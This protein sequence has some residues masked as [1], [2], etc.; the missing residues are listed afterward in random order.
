MEGIAIQRVSGKNTT[1]IVFLRLKDCTLYLK[2]SRQYLLSRARS[3]Y[4]NNKKGVGT[5]LYNKQGNKYK[6]VAYHFTGHPYNA[7]FDFN[8]L[9]YIHFGNQMKL[10]NQDNNIIHDFWN[11]DDCNHFLEQKGNYTQKAIKTGRTVLFNKYGVKFSVVSYI[12]PEYE[13][14]NIPT[15]DKHSSH[16]R[17]VLNHFK[18]GIVL[19]VINKS[20]DDLEEAVNNNAPE[21]QLLRKL[22]G[23]LEK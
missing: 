12:L 22:I 15:N 4:H 10:K 19:S 11:L 20:Y 9:K 1:I 7:N 2:R 3:I 17:R 16:Q 8:S 13:V 18:V 21:L 5:Y 6:I 23:N 14:H